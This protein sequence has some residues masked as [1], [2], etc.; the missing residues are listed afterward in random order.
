MVD[1]FS[2]V[3][4]MLWQS[5]W[6]LAFLTLLIWPISRISRNSH[7]EFAYGLWSILL[8]KALLPFNLPIELVNTTI[9][10]QSANFITQLPQV[11]LGGGSNS[12]ITI[13][14][15]IV[16]LWYGG[17][18]FF[19]VR[20]VVNDIRFRKTLRDATPWIVPTR[21]NAFLTSQKL[22]R[23]PFILISPDIQIP[24]SL[25]LLR[26]RIYLP[27]TVVNWSDSEIL[28][29]IAHEMA[30]IRRLD[31]A[32]IHLQ[33][34]V[35]M[36]YWFHPAIWLLNDQMD[37]E[38]ER[39]CDDAAIRATNADRKGYGRNLL[40][41]LERSTNHVHHAV[42][43]SGFFFTKHSLVRRFE[44]IVRKQSD[45]EE[46][47]KMYHKM[48]MGM[49]VVLALVASCNMGK[50]DRLTAHSESD[51]SLAKTMEDSIAVNFDT[52]PEP[53]GGYGAI[54]RAVQYPDLARK[55]GI[56]GTVIVQTKISITG[57]AV[58]SQVVRGIPEGG[59]NEAA[60]AAIEKVT[61]NPA[62]LHNQPV[63]AM[64]TIP[65]VFRLS[66]EKTD[67]KNK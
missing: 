58:Q 2:T 57:A 18:M 12:T 54:Q 9:Q 61:W 39:I 64:I 19:L 10:R 56:Q 40:N 46:G 7:P 65:V 38:R 33:A 20:L 28:S 36:I 44:Y 24:F 63:E 23:T 52:P 8:L 11:T 15:L 14:L 47:L 59:L 34:I 6:Q 29:V 26:P 17:A 25:G 3:L 67:F 22:A 35:K 1:F 37:L 31:L 13:A 21:V 62:M 51:H 45:L 66:P 53:L 5:S 60:V 27:D 32:V 16:S 42:L 41:Q 4:S 50:D 49:V 43:A 55:A 30:H 48:L